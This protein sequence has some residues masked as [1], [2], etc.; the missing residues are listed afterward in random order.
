MKREIL[1][2]L[3]KVGLQRPFFT[4]IEKDVHAEIPFRDSLARDAHCTFF[5]KNFSEPP[6]DFYKE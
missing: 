4:A 3:L 5:D 1:H 6:L 2:L